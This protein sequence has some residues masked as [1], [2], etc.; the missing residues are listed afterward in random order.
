VTRQ[1]GLGG[2]EV[3]DICQDRTGNLW[4]PVEGQGVYRYDGASF[5]RFYERNG[6]E[7]HAIFGVTED[8]TGRL[9][10]YGFA[11]TWRYDGRSF[12]NVTRDEPW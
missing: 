12:V 9:W 3:G 5:T 1:E 8:R 6:L 4:F 7:S 2:V 10:F 11:G